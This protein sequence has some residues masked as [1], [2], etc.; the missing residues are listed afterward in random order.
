MAWKYVILT[1]LHGAQITLLFR[2]FV[3]DQEKSKFVTG[4]TRKIMRGLLLHEGEGVVWN[5]VIVR[6][7]KSKFVTG[8]TRK[9]MRGLLLHEGFWKT[10]HIW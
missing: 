5:E 10:K 6:K 9:I 7:E 4:S 1:L 2:S 8:S 3:L